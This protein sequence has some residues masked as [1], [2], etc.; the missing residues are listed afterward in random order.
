MSGSTWTQMYTWS[1]PATGSSEFPTTSVTIGASGYY[2]RVV[3]NSVGFSGG[4]GFTVT[5]E[6]SSTTTYT[7]ETQNLTY[8]WNL[9]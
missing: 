6:T 5:G 4:A 9:Y 7:S 3:S 8:T 1:D 2:V